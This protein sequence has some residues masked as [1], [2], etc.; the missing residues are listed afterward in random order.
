MLILQPTSTLFL[1][2]AIF[3]TTEL[4]SD[5]FAIYD[6][7]YGVRNLENGVEFYF[8]LNMRQGRQA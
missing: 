2:K 1:T 7:K 8:E 4:L 3:E 6:N 5:I